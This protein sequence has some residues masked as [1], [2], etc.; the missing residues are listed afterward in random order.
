MTMFG[1]LSIDIAQHWK[2]THPFVD[3]SQPAS[4]HPEQL[5]TASAQAQ[6]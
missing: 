2:Q 3:D 6:V 4:T 1:C 5:N